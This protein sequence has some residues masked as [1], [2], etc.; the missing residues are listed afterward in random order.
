[1]THNQQQLTMQQGGQS[2]L[3]MMQ[4]QRASSQAL[5]QAIAQMRAG[6]AGYANTLSEGLLQAQQQQ[7]ALNQGRTNLGMG[8]DIGVTGQNADMARTMAGFD[9]DRSVMDRNTLSGLA[10]TAGSAL[11]QY[12]NSAGTNTSGGGSGKKE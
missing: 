12:R 6:D 7:N 8:Y 1:M 4:Q 11:E 10:Q 3:L 9:Y 2:A 5:S